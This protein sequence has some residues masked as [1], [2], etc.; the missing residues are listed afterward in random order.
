MAGDAGGLDAWLDSTALA[1]A[2]KLSIGAAGSLTPLHQARANQLIV[3]AVGRQRVKLVPAAQVGRLAEDGGGFS[4]IA[5]LDDPTLSFQAH[6]RLKG[7]RVYDLE[8]AAGEALFAPVGWWLQARAAD[9]SVSVAFANFRWPNDAAAAYP[10]AD[11]G[12]LAA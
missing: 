7:L 9:L 8:L 1:S 3:Q 5:D 2:G 6:P 4:A 12:D 10:V 11:P